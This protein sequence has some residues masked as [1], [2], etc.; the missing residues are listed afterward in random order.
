MKMKFFVSTIFSAIVMFVCLTATQAAETDPRFLIE[1]QEQEGV[2]LD[3]QSATE[4]ALPILWKRVVPSADLERAYKLPAV[5]SL[6]LQFKPVK[7]GVKM[8]F[9]PIQVRQYLVAYK[10]NMIPVQPYWNLSV[11]SLGISDSDEQLSTDLL[12]Y[13]YSMSDEFG[14]R[15]GPRGKKLQIM[16]S[17]VNDPYG[18]LILHADV[19]GAF[20]PD[21]LSQ[22][23]MKLAGFASVQT[24]DFLNQILRE[25]RDAYSL[26]KMTFEDVS[27]DVL[28]TIELEYSLASQVMLEQALRTHPSVVNVI[29]TL[30][31]KARR[32]YRIQLR[33]GNDQWLESWFARYGLVAIRQPEGS[34][35]DWLVQ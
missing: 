22:T 24:Y 5:T 2:A 28:L 4:Q 32:Q 1:L 16:F 26:G 7:H 20:P 17:S 27:T 11:F 30:L 29:P 31:Q 33:D 6:L 35:D 25:I 34:V 21:L 18:E 10:I 12:N 8:V 14:F 23:D 3:I 13:S 9:N 15:L 19:Q